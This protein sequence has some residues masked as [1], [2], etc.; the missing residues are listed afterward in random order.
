MFI[1]IFHTE[2]WSCIPYK[3]STCLT[4]ARSRDTCFFAAAIMRRSV[5]VL[6]CPGAGQYFCIIS[7]WQR[8]RCWNLALHFFWYKAFWFQSNSLN[9]SSHRSVR[10]S[11]QVT[12]CLHG[13]PGAWPLKTQLL[14]SQAASIYFAETFL[15]S[16][17]HAA[18]MP[19]WFLFHMNN[20]WPP[21]C[22][23]SLLSN[24]PPTQHILKQLCTYPHF[25]GGGSYC[26]S[27][28]FHKA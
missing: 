2:I 10:T 7:L 21:A 22:Q 23:L 5:R 12:P 17:L 20:I 11:E 14:F 25:W 9:T 6:P 1:Y 18:L 3:R 19:F 28:L 8:D 16:S 13:A 24:L 26:F 4:T 15:M 27:Y